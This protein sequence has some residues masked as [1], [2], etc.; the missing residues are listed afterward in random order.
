[1]WPPRRLFKDV[2]DK[3]WQPGKIAQTPLNAAI[4]ERARRQL[5]NVTRAQLLELGLSK[6]GIEWRLRS[7][8]LASRYPGVYAIA[9]ERI[10][11][12]ALAVAAV[13]ACGPQAVLS[14]ASA[15]YLWGLI[16]YWEP[17]PEVT[18]TKG[19]R[20]PRGILTHRCPAL[21]RRDVTRQRDVPIT[22]PER[23][24][25]DMTPRLTTKQRTRMVNDA[26]LSGYV[27]LATLSDVLA[28]NPF[29]PGTKLLRPLAEDPSN[30]TR[31][32]FEDDFRVF[33]ARHDLPTPLINTYVNGYEVD[34]YFPDHKLI[35]ELDSREYHSDEEA[36]EDDRE[37]DAEQLKHGVRTVRITTA[38]FTDTPVAEAAR[39]LEIMGL[40]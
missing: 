7:G 30:P 15:A 10:D 17:L 32:G 13:L 2:G 35:V 29:H 33:A 6:G 25:L 8:S 38:R 19:D 39:L 28:R 16:R 20:R 37:R 9:P 4:R 22:S 26:R 27:H 1:M 24:V 21:K 5:G 36:F 23:T 12:P 18:L 3:H 14:H 11:P 40:Q 34:A 31:S